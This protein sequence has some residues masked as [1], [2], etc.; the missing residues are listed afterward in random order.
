MQFVQRLDYRSGDDKLCKPFVVRR[1][2]IPGRVT[3]R[4]VTDH[5]LVCSHVRRPELPLFHILLLEFPVLAWRFDAFQEPFLLLLFG[6][7]REELPHRGS[8]ARE[9]SFKCA[10]V[11]KPLAPDS[12]F[13]YQRFR[14]LFVR[15]HR[16]MNPHDEDFLVV[17]AVK[18]A[19]AAAL[20]QT[21][22][23]TPEKI[24]AQFLVRWLLK[25]DDLAAHRVHAR[26]HV[27]DQA[28]F[29]GRIHALQ[30][31]EHRP[32]FLRIQLFLAVAQQFEALSQQ[33]VR[34]LLGWNA[35]RI[36]G[37]E[38]FQAE[39]A[40]VLDAIALRKLFECRHSEVSSY[41]NACPNADIVEPMRLRLFLLL[42]AV[43]PV[44][45]AD[46]KLVWSDE[47]NA[48]RR[49]PP[50]PAKWVYDL[51]GGGWGNNELEVY[52]DKPHNVAQ[53]GA[54]HL[55]IRALKSNSGKY[56]SARIK[57]QGKYTV[58]YGKI[59]ARMKI[60]HGQGIWPAFWMLGE[61]IKTVDWPACGEID[62][63]ENIG[64]EPSIV[65]GTIHGPG[66]SGGNGIGHS[67]TLANGAPLSENFHVYA[68]EWSSDSITFLLDDKAYAT[69]TPRDLP[70]GT[71]WVY[72]HPFFLLLNLAIGGNWPGNPDGTTQFPQQLVVDWVRV[73]QKQK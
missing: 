36:A 31:E 39:F 29:A 59:A 19:D 15:K 40:A 51:G 48:A 41:P 18:N 6:K 20:G 71:H 37:I 55:V 62:V 23:S 38:V 27:L 22:S 21:G 45:A 53:D 34:L 50:D 16:R 42:I 70:P 44:R 46:W 63:M 43:L 61:D 2:D 73:W 49:T 47:F 58:Q 72:N 57:T 14:N 67:A 25:G 11:F 28:V 66:Y 9:V 32:L 10:N 65:H 26:H 33:F 24:V 7:I 12:L 3:G 8:V 30:N 5:V 13:R 35:A 56:T 52:T 60:P 68:V 4:R 1:N 17:G 64:K 54:G 69:V